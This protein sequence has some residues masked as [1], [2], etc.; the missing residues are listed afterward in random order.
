MPDAVDDR[1]GEINLRCK[2]GVARQSAD[3]GRVR[4]PVSNRQLPR[5]ERCTRELPD[6]LD[7]LFGTAWCHRA[8]R[9][10]SCRLRSCRNRR[11][12]P[13]RPA[14][15]LVR[16]TLKSAPGPSRWSPRAAVT[17]VSRMVAPGSTPLKRI[18]VASLV[19]T[20]TSLCAS[21][22]APPKIPVWKPANWAGRADPSRA[23]PPPF[24]LPG[25]RPSTAWPEL[26]IAIERSWRLELPWST[27]STVGWTAGDV[28]VILSVGFGNP[29]P[30][31]STLLAG[32]TSL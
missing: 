10:V 25:R 15:M 11:K 17:V 14:E 29:T 28:V 30:R 32:V 12:E 2:A 22:T 23:D 20:R 6:D 5:A 4:V 18:P 3:A 26:G 21:V 16:V 19:E 13:I 7:R 9:S 1:A 8:C 31:I 27:V 24:L